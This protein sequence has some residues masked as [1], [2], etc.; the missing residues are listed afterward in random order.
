[1]VAAGTAGS[2]TIT[3]TATNS[4]GTKTQSFTLTITNTNSAPTTIFPSTSSLTFPAGSPASLTFTATGN[5]KNFKIF[6]YS[7]TMPTGLNLH[8]AK[9]GT[10]TVSGTPTTKGQLYLYLGS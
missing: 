10:A 7:G 9:N 3:I 2:Y 5:G 6:L 4:A 8:D 1:M